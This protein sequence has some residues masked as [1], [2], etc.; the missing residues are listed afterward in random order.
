MWGANVGL[1]LPRRMWATCA[2]SRPRTASVAST[3]CQRRSMVA[4]VGV[5]VFKGPSG[6]KGERAAAQRPVRLAQGDNAHM[7]DLARAVAVLTSPDL[8][9][10][11]DMVAYPDDGWVVAANGRGS[12]RFRAVST[13]DGGWDFDIAA[14]EADNPLGEQDPTRFGTL[15]EE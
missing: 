6:R 10:I 8:A 15:A 14:L 9:P 4:G 12:V 1:C 11:C 3:R 7:S 2:A 5:N 13:G